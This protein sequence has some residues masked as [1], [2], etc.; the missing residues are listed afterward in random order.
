MEKKYND[1]NRVKQTTQKKSKE[2][3]FKERDVF[4]AK[5]GENI[6]FEQNGKGEEF[7]RPV[8]IVKK[9]STNM[10]LAIPLSTTIRN[11]SFFFQFTFKDKTSTALLVQNRL[12]SS[13]RLSKKIGKID[14]VNFKLMKEKLIDLIK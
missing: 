14:E 8:V 7:T 2:L 12:M 3:F 1:W 10:F 13:K 4:W 5:L 9:Y 6:G 11:G